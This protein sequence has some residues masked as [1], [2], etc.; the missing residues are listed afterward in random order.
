[1]LKDELGSVIQAASLRCGTCPGLR[2]SSASRNL[3]FIRRPLR[4]SCRA[5]E[6]A[7]WSVLIPPSSR[8]GKGRDPRSNRDTSWLPLTEEF[9]GD[10]VSKEG[11]L[12]P[13]ISRW[14]RTPA[15]ASDASSHSI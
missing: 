14:S 2:N 13:G 8:L 1:N 7:L 5:S 3:G 9:N 12:V 10:R 11:K 6:S 15:P 4:E